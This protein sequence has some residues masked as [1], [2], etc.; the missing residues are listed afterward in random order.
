MKIHHIG[1]IVNDIEKSICLYEKLGYIR[2][3]DIIQDSIQNIEVA[4]IK[5]KDNTQV[6]ELIRAINKLSTI[7]NFKEGYHH[8]CYEVAS[9]ERFMEEFK[10]LRI[11]KIFTK[12]IMA[13]AI[14]N[15]QV[16][17]GCLSN[18]LFVEFIL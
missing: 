2:T 1:I 12:P 15:R 7:Y 3:S 16:V 4:F 6:I 9:N 8:I 18:G 17:F 14:N 11:G 10:C 5:S 13:P